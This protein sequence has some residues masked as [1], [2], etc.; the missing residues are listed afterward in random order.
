MLAISGLSVGADIHNESCTAFEADTRSA[1]VTFNDIIDVTIFSSY[2]HVTHLMRGYGE[3]T[4]T[5][6]YNMTG[7]NIGYKGGR[8][9]NVRQQ[10]YAER[11]RTVSDTEHWLKDFG[12]NGKLALSAEETL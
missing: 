12:S 4:P 7:R 2:C 6:S 10:H 3:C 9:K 1:N 8:M 5:I 11:G